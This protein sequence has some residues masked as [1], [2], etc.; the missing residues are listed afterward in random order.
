MP[1]FEFVG[2]DPIEHF[3]L[4]R[5]EPGEVRD[6][7]VPPAGPWRA[8]KRRRP[9]PAELDGSEVTPKES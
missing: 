1:K 4:G 8:V 2:A 9:E 3:H 5:V 7:D 6:L